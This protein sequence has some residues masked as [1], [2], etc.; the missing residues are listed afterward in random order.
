MAKETSGR[1]AQ[2]KHKMKL[3]TLLIAGALA[4]V[5]ASLP[6]VA[7]ATHLT[8]TGSEAGP[9]VAWG[10]NDDWGWSNA[11]WSSALTT[12]QLQIA[13]AI[14]PDSLSAN[15][16]H[17]QWAKVERLKGTYDWAETDAQYAAMQQYAPRPVM[18]LFN[19]PA[20]AR[21]PAATCPSTDACGYPPLSKYDSDWNRFVR[22]AAVRYPA[23]RA[24]EIWNEPNL[25]SFWAP[26]PNSRRY[27]SLLK[28]AHDAA[29]AAGSSAPVL[30]GGLAPAGNSTTTIGA[31]EFLNQV[32]AKGCSCYFEGIGAHP[33]TTQLPLVENMWK[34]LDKLR[35]IRDGRGDNATPLWITEMGLSSNGTSGVTAATQGSALVELY[36]SVEG[37]DI[38]SFIIHRFHDI[39]YEDSYW[40]RT[41]VVL[42]DLSRK[43]AYCTLGHGIGTAPVGC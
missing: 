22:A 38:A 29:V 4:F 27:V 8:T 14:M 42:E 33:Y 7:S 9:T 35:A 3:R 25:G 24:I 36:R 12:Q 23:V 20:W 31:A 39:G 34:R 43:P 26:K 19:A 15:R 6:S 21:D 11:G 18:L 13:G 5:P 1:P 40:N 17:V 2:K 16:F 41:G 30:I 28:S 10:F 32:Y 37:H